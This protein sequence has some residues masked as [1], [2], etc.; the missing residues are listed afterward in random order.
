MAKTTNP[1]DP[2]CPAGGTRPLGLYIHLP[3]CASRCPYCDFFALPLAAGPARALMPALL[4]HWEMIAPL[5]G[6]RPLDHVY[7]GG[8]TPSLLPAGQI[9]RLLE[10]AR[11]LLGFS[12]GCE[13]TLEANPGTLGAGKLKALQAAGV[14]RLSLGTQSFDARLLKLL[15]RRHTPQ[16]TRRAVA[17][18]RAAGFANLSLD[19]IHGLPG[20]TPQLARG[21]LLAALE[22]APEHLSLYEL[23]LAPD[24]PFGRA[25]AKGRPPLPSEDEVLAMED[26]ALELLEAGGL[27]R[28]EVSNFA[29]PGHACRHNQDTWR[30]GD[31]LALGP[32]AHGHL[33]GRRW[34]WV[35]EVAAYVAGVEGGREPLEFSEDL[36]PRQR[37]WELIMLGLRTVE[38]VDLARVGALLGQDPRCTWASPLAQL[39]GQGWARLDGQRLV[40]TPLGLR[41]ADAAAELFL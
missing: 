4:C 10:A 23:T 34:A 11:H 6:G 27:A 28:Y 29:R 17:Q 19:L 32:G 30:G 12:P 24:T 31:Y 16:D 33:A 26:A 36:T 13:I 22:L 2:L 8:G 40:P 9:A 15:G 18:A 21:D 38:G 35:A 20:Q 14:N 37:A 1:T 7:L 39:T 41:L 25:Y 3:F 5:A